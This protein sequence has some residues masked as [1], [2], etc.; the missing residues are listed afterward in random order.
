MTRKHPASNERRANL[1]LAA[2]ERNERS[3]RRQRYR[4]TSCGSPEH[5]LVLTRPWT[6]NGES[7]RGVPAEDH[8]DVQR[9]HQAATDAGYR[10]NGSPGER[11]RYH[12]GYYAATSSIS[13]ARTSNSSATAARFARQ[14]PRRAEHGRLPR[15]GVRRP[16]QAATPSRARGFAAK[17]E[18]ASRDRGPRLTQRAYARLGSRRRRDRSPSPQKTST[19]FAVDEHFCCPPGVG[20]ID[21]SQLMGAGSAAVVRLRDWGCLPSPDPSAREFPQSQVARAAS[22]RTSASHVLALAGWMGSGCRRRVQSC[23]F[24]ETN[25]RGRP[26]MRRGPRSSGQPG[27]GIH[28]TSRSRARSAPACSTPAQQLRGRRERRDTDEFG[29]TSPLTAVGALLFSCGRLRVPV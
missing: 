8:A 28:P 19:D 29:M 16:R 17:G 21:R 27:G 24:P 9:F 23:H 20:W 26:V 2:A 18:L 4:A 22:S 12:P 25:A 3:R 11:P 13:P 5:R 6:A 14:S 15:P 10:R 7:P 1:R